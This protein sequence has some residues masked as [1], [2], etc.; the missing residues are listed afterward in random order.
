MSLKGD[1][2]LRIQLRTV[3]SRIRRHSRWSIRF[4]GQTISGMLK[5]IVQDDRTARYSSN[6]VTPPSPRSSSI[7]YERPLV[8]TLWGNEPRSRGDGI[9]S[10]QLRCKTAS[11]LAISAATSGRLGD[12]SIAV[13]RNLLSASTDQT[14]RVWNPTVLNPKPRKSLALAWGPACRGGDSKSMRLLREALAAA[15]VIPRVGDI[16]V[17]VANRMARSRSCAVIHSRKS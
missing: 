2:P 10:V 11:E 12:R 9:R 15:D 7:T 8:A 5:V 3:R 1:E 6:R 4:A 17:A 16:I 13:G 14:L